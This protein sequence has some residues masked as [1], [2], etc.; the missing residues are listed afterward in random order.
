[1]DY[2][3]HGEFD[4][5]TNGK[6]SLTRWEGNDCL[7]YSSLVYAHGQR[8]IALTGEDWTSILDGQAGVPFP[9]DADCW[10]SWKG[11]ERKGE[12]HVPF[13]VGKVQEL[14]LIHISEP[15]RPY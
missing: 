15:T 8:N 5:G 6:L 9:G 14:S 13:T 12:V 10:W 2:A 7:N 11:R 4:C 1:M 3:R